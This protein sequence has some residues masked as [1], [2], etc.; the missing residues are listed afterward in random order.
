MTRATSRHSLLGIG[1]RTNNLV[2]FRSAPAR[3]RSHL[4]GLFFCMGD[5]SLLAPFYCSTAKPVE[6]AAASILNG[7]PFGPYRRSSAASG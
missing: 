6:S 3:L 7:D 4:L 5:R 2:G 1:S